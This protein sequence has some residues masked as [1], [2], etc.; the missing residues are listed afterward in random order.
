MALTGSITPVRDHPLGRRQT[1]QQ[2]GS[3]GIVAD[4]ACGHE[5]LQGPPLGVGDGMQLGVQPTFRAPDQ[6]P[7]LVVGPPF[8][9]R[10]LE[11]VWCA[12]R[13]VASIMMVFCSVPSEASPSIIRAK[14]PMSP[15]RFQRL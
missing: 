5:D 13:Y 8:F 4:L 12:L 10:R 2:G 11:A 9:A 1:A 15:H 6:A 7:A 14:T 3:A